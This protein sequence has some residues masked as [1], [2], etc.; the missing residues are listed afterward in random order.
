MRLSF[1]NAEI[2][3]MGF[4]HPENN[5]EFLGVY[6]R[7]D[8]EKG[9]NVLHIIIEDAVDK[10]YVAV[11]IKKPDIIYLKSFIEAYLENNNQ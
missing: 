2:Y 10:T 6:V 5:H 3:D 7:N 9:E 4:L 8:E 1:E 11:S